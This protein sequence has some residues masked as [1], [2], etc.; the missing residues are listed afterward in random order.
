MIAKL[1]RE[2]AELRALE[3]IYC[4]RHCRHAACLTVILVISLS[5]MISCGKEESKTEDFVY[6]G[7]SDYTYGHFQYHYS[8]GSRY[9]NEM[10]N[11]ATHYERFLKELCEMLS[12]PIPE[13]KIEFYIYMP[14]REAK[15]ITGRD[16][17]FSNDTEIHWSG[18]YPYGYELAKFLLRKK[19]IEPGKFHAISD[20][21]PHV[22][23]FSGI[24]YHD[25]MNRLVNSNQ[26]VGLLDLGN[27]EVYDT[28]MFAIKRTESAS[29]AGFIM[30][31]YGIDRLLMLWQSK[32]DWKESI[33]TIFQLSVDV[34]EKG[35]LEFAL[36]YADD[37]EGTV[38]NDTL[39]ATRTTIQ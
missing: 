34:F 26:N 25:K 16:T 15:D 32:T 7:W 2:V 4:S 1:N 24:N 39:P 11:L 21:V 28:L 19:G 27:N 33:E 31:N 36:A 29:L 12:V 23:D 20:G 35:W 13:E 8:P 17:P 3:N 18:K 30:Y 6:E 38:E 10:N 37:P 9:A 5:V 14:G 22:L